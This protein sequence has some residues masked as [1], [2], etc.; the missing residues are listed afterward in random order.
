[1]KTLII[2]P[3]YNEELNIKKTVNDITENTEI[4][5]TAKVKLKGYN[6][7]INDEGK[8]SY[9][10]EGAIDNEDI[11][12]NP[13]NYY[14]KYVTNYTTLSDEGIKDENGQLGKWQI[15]LADDTNIYLIASNAIHK[16]YAPLNYNSNG[17]YYM[18][19]TDILGLYDTSTAGNPSVATILGKLNKQ[20]KYHEWLSK[21]I[22]SNK[23]S[24]KAV[25]SMLDTDRWNE[26][27][28]SEK[29][30]KG[31]LNSIYA[32]YVI[33]GPTL[34]MFFESY[35]KTH[36]GF[37]LIPRPKNDSNVYYQGGY[38]VRKEST[39]IITDE[40]MSVSG[41]LDVSQTELSPDINSN[42]YFKNYT[43]WLASPLYGGGEVFRVRRGIVD[44]GSLG[45]SSICFRPLVCLN[46]DVHLI[47]K[48]NGTTTTY[49][50]ELD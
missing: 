6:Y 31:F 12:A 2:I 30:E 14:G 20:D 39:E 28:D 38:K 8:V 15:F 36:G 34:E 18:Y 44:S 7:K 48:T 37:D 13:S 5:L 32:S 4:Q 17:D 42:M 25:L 33:G 21:A 46:S 22:L 3:A 50:L 24:Q 23:G 41:L 29:N 40:A 43:F 1:M 26:Y 27:E 16:D 11:I 47:E 49:E 35:N 10:K 45:N 9:K 19:F